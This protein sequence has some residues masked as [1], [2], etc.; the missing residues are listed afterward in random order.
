VYSSNSQTRGFDRKAIYNIAKENNGGTGG[1]P[2]GIN[3]EISSHCSLIYPYH[4]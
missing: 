4:K 1:K 2:A 3:Y